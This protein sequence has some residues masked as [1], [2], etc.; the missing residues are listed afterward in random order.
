MV[1][2]NISRKHTTFSLY[3]KR[4]SIWKRVTALA[5]ILLLAVPT[6]MFTLNKKD[7]AAIPCPCSLLPANPT[8]TGTDTH[9]N[10]LE[11][12]FKFRSSLSGY[13]VG[14]RFFK[15]AGM[16]GTHTGSLWDNMGNR[17]A[18]ATFQSETASGWQQVNFSSPVAITADTLYT[19]STFMANGVYAYT[20]NYYTSPVTNSPITAPANGTPQAADG[21]GQSGQG[22]AELSGVS[23]YPTNSFNSA[24]YWVDVS[25][26]GAPDSDP[27]EV[28]GVEPTASSTGANIGTSVSATFDIP[29]LSTSLTTNTFT[30]KDASNNA[31]SGNVSYNETTRVATFSPTS[32][33]L[34]NTTY[35][36]TIEGGSGTVARSLDDIALASD[37]SWSFTT[38]ATDS[39]PCSL[40]SRAAPI[41]GVTADD[42]SG[43]ELGV[44]I[45]PQANGY[46]NAIRFY[47][48]IISTLSSHTGN[49]WSSTGT[50]LATVTF[51]NESEYGWQEAKL[52]SPLAVTKGQLYIVSYGVPDG[53]YQATNGA[54]N[55]TITADSLTA[56][57]TGSSQNAATGSGNS[58]GVFVTT[59][60]S[61]PNTGSGTGTYYWIDAVFSVTSGL[62]TTLTPTVTQPKANAYGVQ[63]DEPITVSFPRALDSGTVSGSTVRL[64]DSSNSQVAGTVSYSTANGN[65]ISF[66]PAADLTNG[67][68]YTARL[69]A[70]IADPAGM[71]L[72]SEYSWSFTVGSQLSS[73]PTAGPGGPVLVVT[74]TATNKFSTYYAEILRAEGMNYF[75]TRD[76]STVTAGVLGAYDVVLL[77]ETAL[78]QSQADM[79]STWVDGGGN[80][81]AMRP[82]K[83]LASLLGLTDVS[84]TRT[85]QYM[86]V[87]TASGPGVGIVNE[88]MQFKGVADNYTLNGAT[89]VA[90]FYSNASTSTSNPAVTKRAVGSNGGTAVAFAYD[91]AKSVTAL[92]Q[93]NVAWAGQDRDGSS[94]VRTN[95][96]FY[97]ART[98]DVQPD[99]V[100]LNKIHIPQADE[101]QRLLA[102][103]MTDV[104][105]DRKPLPRFWYLPGDTKAAML[106]AGDDH[107]LG[108]EATERVLNNWL[109]ESPTGCSIQDWECVRASHYVYEASAL[110]N[111]RAVQYDRLKQEVADHISNS[112]SCNDY[113]SF[114]NLSNRFTTDLTTW[115]AKFTGLANQKTLRFHC[116]L[117]S[118]WDSMQ[119]VEAAN[120]MRYDLGYVAYPQTW[121]NGKSPLLTGSGMNMRFTDLDGDM[122]DVYQGV[123]NFDNTAADATQIGLLLDSAL[124]SEGYYGIYGSHYDMSDN[125]HATVYTAAKSRNIPMI[126]SRQALTWADGRGSSS[127]SNFTG[128]NGQFSFTVNAAEGAFGL[129]AMLPI[130]DAGGTLSTLSAEG[131]TVTYQTQTVK[132]VQYAVFDAN[133]GEYTATYSDYTTPN[134]GGGGNNGGG[135]SGGQSG[136]SG[137]SSTGGS[138]STKKKSG[139][140]FQ[141]TDPDLT[142]LTPGTTTPQPTISEQ[143]TPNQNGDTDK[144]EKEF[145]TEAKEDGGSLVSWLIGIGGLFLLLLVL[146]AILAAKRRRKRDEPTWQ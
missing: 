94:M 118:D 51:S 60:G 32:P 119:K 38:A 14:V 67:E 88:T 36:A 7:A 143:P 83:K 131:S 11:V 97:G 8:P 52:S 42:V 139:G 134:P 10:G 47:K 73:D 61:Y 59:A 18:T 28:S 128:S 87:D 77:A 82:D 92:H 4:Y 62:V 85:N 115:R 68:R 105:K 12:G 1:V 46:I 3:K 9:T 120:G 19:A 146:W 48:P 22:V 107:G 23:L 37:Y 124:G 43:Y 76:L 116:Y 101:Q 140:L 90:T 123:T 132:G 114:A 72:G 57:A 54:H 21:L 104:A 13:I 96:L 16:T 75:D 113:T 81:V 26:T 70:S 45:V 84:S 108:N 39:C 63:K 91:L 122:I 106:L 138:T 133:P 35:T 33:L 145:I 5:V 2:L 66:D 112:N 111:S 78:S 141:N 15:M 126:S 102:N 44:K 71:T 64:F 65:I 56:Y 58:N 136:S 31:V 144:K 86:L 25:F 40:K 129:R 29:M 17:I 103:L 20:T 69:S 74:N 99:W 130:N 110:T 100:D 30:V 80:L 49:I 34:V 55:T 24:N 121:L 89:A 127:F 41:G 53:V 79:L 117:L 93:G 142:N 6:L 109:N 95:D 137:S 125:Y 135:S 98:G 50:N 27:P